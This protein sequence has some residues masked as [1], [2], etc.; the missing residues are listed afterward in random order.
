MNMDSYDSKDYRLSLSLN[1]ISANIFISN[2]NLQLTEISVGDAHLLDLIKVRPYSGM[3]PGETPEFKIFSDVPLELR[4]L[5]SSNNPYFAYD[6][7]FKNNEKIQPDKFLVKL[8]IFFS[9]NGRDKNIN[10][11][12]EIDRKSKNEIKPLD[13]HSDVSFLFIPL[14]GALALLLFVIRL[15]IM[16]TMIM[17][18]RRKGEE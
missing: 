3:D 13:V 5:N 15:A 10:K 17:L 14:F 12:F 16:A 18:R 1:K 11:E 2:I 4:K 7:I 6:F 8:N 9:E